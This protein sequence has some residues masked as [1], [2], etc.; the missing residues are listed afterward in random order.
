M[1]ILA[2]R[3]SWYVPFEVF[4]DILSD[5]MSISPTLTPLGTRKKVAVAADTASVSCKALT[6]KKC[7]ETAGSQCQCFCSYSFFC[8]TQYKRCAKARP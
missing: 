3:L 8:G 1:G 7:C 2:S 4:H 6:F 5:W